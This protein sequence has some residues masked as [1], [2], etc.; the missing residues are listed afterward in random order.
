VPKV[1]QGMTDQESWYSEDAFWE[2]VEP[3]LFNQQR[4]SRAKEEVD[5]IEKLLEIDERANILDLC[6]GIGR[7]SLE[8][9]GRGYDVTGVDRT[10]RYIEA[11]RREAKKR[12]MDAKFVVADMRDY[13]SSNS[14]DV[15]LNLFGSFGYF[16]NSA[17]DQRV[18]QNMYDSL[19]PGGNFLIETM[20]KE[21]LARDFQARDWDEEGDLLILSEKKITQNWGRVET[22]W[23]AIRGTD[24]IEHQVSIRSYSASEL[25]TLLRSCGFSDVRVYGSID[26]AEYDQAAPRLVVVGCR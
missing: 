24:R 20:G 9:S 11:A 22:R 1:K 15:V 19:R 10:E 8:L 21:I 6:C 5:K 3:L 2:L 26:G 12:N 4:R 25:A 18:V 13:R 23:I 7:H 14:Y 16:E 17:D